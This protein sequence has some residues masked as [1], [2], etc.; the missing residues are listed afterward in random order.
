MPKRINPETD[1]CIHGHTGYWY[2]NAAG[3]HVCRLCH[4]ARNSKGEKVR[5]LQNKARLMPIYLAYSVIPGAVEK[6]AALLHIKPRALRGYLGG[7]YAAPRWRVAQLKAVLELCIMPNGG[8]GNGHHK[9][10]ETAR[11]VG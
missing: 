2:V 5:R 9:S 3:F 10:A 7:W 1:A 8:N 4:R 11:S 6:A